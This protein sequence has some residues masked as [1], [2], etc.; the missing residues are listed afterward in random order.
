MTIRNARGVQF[1][2]S[3]IETASGGPWMLET[4]TEVSGLK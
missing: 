2:N 4:N 1:K 3:K